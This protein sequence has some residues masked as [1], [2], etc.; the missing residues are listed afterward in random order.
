MPMFDVEVVAADC[1]VG[2]IG[3]VMAAQLAV[4]AIHIPDIVVVPLGTFDIAG[5]RGMRSCIDY[6][7]IDRCHS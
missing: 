4:V 5:L 7:S 6:R 1:H 3:F 2:R